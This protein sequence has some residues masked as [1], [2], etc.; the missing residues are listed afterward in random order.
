MEIEIAAQTLGALA[1][2]SRLQVFRLLVNAGPEGMSAGDIAR[3]VGSRANT[4]S[5]NLSVLA[6]ARLVTSRRDGRLIIYSA[7][8]E[9]MR[10]LLT[11]LVEDCCGGKPELCG[12]LVAAVA[13]GGAPEGGCC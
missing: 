5:A 12:P 6:A 13:A 9:T 2:T 4:L 3:A 10:Q 1:Y 7:E 11:F 8:Y